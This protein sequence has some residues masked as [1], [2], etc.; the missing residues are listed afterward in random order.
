MSDWQETSIQGAWR[1]SIDFHSDLRGSF[2]ELWR[3]SETRPLG[4]GAFVQANVSRSE[5]NVVRGMHFHLRQTDAWAILEGGALVA[6]VDLRARIAD[7]TAPAPVLTQTLVAG[8]V[9]VIPEG[10][11]H[12]FWALERITLLYLV[13]NEYDGTDEHGFAW[14]DPLAAVPWPDAA[15]TLSDRDR[16]LGGVDA[17]VADARQRSGQSPGR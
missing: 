14:N 10:V 2:A 15:V 13:T 6:L 8:D 1:R 3:L 4:T 11:A 9:L 5:M 12:G 7:E 17:A 16:A